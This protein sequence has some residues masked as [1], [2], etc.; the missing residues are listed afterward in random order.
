[1]ELAPTARD[2][3]VSL[4]SNAI[5]AYLTVVRFWIPPGTASG[6]GVWS[7]PVVTVIGAPT[8]TVNGV[9]LDGRK[10]FPGAR[11]L[12]PGSFPL[13]ARQEIT[14]LAG[15]VASGTRIR[16]ESGFHSW[17]E[18]RDNVGP[19]VWAFN[20][21]D[22]CS[23]GLVQWPSPEV[24]PDSWKSFMGPTAEILQRVPPGVPFFESEAVVCQADRVCL[25]PKMLPLPM[26]HGLPL[27]QIFAPDQGSTGFREALFLMGEGL[28]DELG[29]LNHPIC[30]RPLA[31]RRCPRPSCL[32]G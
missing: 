23:A 13:P 10:A 28:P 9:S 6:G 4:S 32:S 1:M 11:T 25:L 7:N 18:Y 27:G 26:C 21:L 12:D 8:Q 2:R 16:P 19:H 15:T 5:G 30:R 29:Y 14:I 24:L 3:Y 20:G 31:R 22:A 17:T